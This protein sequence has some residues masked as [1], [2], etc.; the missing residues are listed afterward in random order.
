MKK[1]SIYINDCIRWS[2]GL[3]ILIQL[4]SS[5][6]YS[7]NITFELVYV[8][9]SFLTRLLNFFRLLLRGGSY[10]VNKL[11]DDDLFAKF[12]EYINQN[13]LEIKK[14]KYRDFKR[15]KTDEYLFPVMKINSSLIFFKF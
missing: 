15:K 3:N 12:E 8:I 9:P 1:I 4:I 6:K 11:I 10:K 13:D 5:L 14:F 7:N 2:G